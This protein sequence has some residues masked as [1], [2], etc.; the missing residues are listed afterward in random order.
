[1][2]VLALPLVPPVGV[3]CLVRKCGVWIDMEMHRGFEVFPGTAVAP[4]TAVK[5]QTDI[6]K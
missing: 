4:T 5:A 6:Q 3:L 2:A 1:M